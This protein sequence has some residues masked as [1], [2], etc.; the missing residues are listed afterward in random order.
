MEAGKMKH[1][2]FEALL[3]DIDHLGHEERI[4]LEA[5]LRECEHCNVLAASWSD[6]EGKMLSAPQMEPASGFTERFRERLVVYKRRKQ[7]R[8]TLAVIL[9]IL[10]SLI[11]VTGF[12]GAELLTFVPSVV[13]F[14]LKSIS[15]L[16]MLGGLLTI[17]GDFTLVLLEGIT[18]SLPAGLLLAIA[19]ATSGL[20]VIWMFSIYRTGFNTLRRE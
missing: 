20:A 1:P 18:Q 19:A 16:V 4:A 2:Q 13:S 14:L 11:I 7:E 3:F 15:G 5:H 6:L 17:L 10:M 9:A 12:F 8:L